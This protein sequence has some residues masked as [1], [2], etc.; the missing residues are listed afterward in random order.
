MSAGDRIAATK[1]SFE[2]L[3]VIY[4]R[5][6]ASAAELID[7]TGL[8]RGGVY[9]H[10]RTLVDVDALV[11]RDG[12]YA[13]GPKFTR[14]GLGTTDS[15]TVAEQTGKVDELAR[16]LDAPANLWIH[17]DDRC[18]CIYTTLA[19]SRDGYPRRRGDSEPLVESP[20]GK[21]ILAYV[22]TGSDA[23][24]AEP[25]NR[26][27]SKQLETLRERRLLEEPLS[28]APEWVSIATPVLDPS[29]H[30]VAAIEI[31]IPS[32]RATGID[33]KNNISGLLTE[34]ANRI[35]VEML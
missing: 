30:P 28:F 6:G 29:D 8:S 4:E 17:D 24:P 32:E 1:T 3:D 18:H 23:G 34:T 5:Q 13:L 33:V 12:V 19:T 35:R 31:V 21:V 7:A 27:L 14:Y 26:E 2:I 9:K 16:S 15:P 22:S 10:L 20:P 11:N 25:E